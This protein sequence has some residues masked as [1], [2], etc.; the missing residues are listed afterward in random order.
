MPAPRLVRGS[1]AVVTSQLRADVVFIAASSF[2]GRCEFLCPS[3]STRGSSDPGRDT[4]R[5]N[6]K[7]A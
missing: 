5:H 4:R 7:T 2:R 6:E 3:S 1:R